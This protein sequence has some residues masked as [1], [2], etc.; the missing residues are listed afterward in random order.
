[1]FELF[2][3]IF[4]LLFLN[5]IA[6]LR[7]CKEPVDCKIELS[8]NLPGFWVNIGSPDFTIQNSKCYPSWLPKWQ[9]I[10]N[11][12][13]GIRCEARYMFRL[14]WI[15]HLCLAWGKSELEPFYFNS[16]DLTD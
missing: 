8:I 13:Q 9:L 7:R 15:F 10:D 2:S 4:L 16:E 1:M 11:D 3:L 6:V 5:F 12:K 14:D